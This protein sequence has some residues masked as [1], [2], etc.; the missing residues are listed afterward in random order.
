MALSKP[1]NN[2]GAS[3]NPTTN[4]GNTRNNNGNP[5]EN[6]NKEE[7]QIGLSEMIKE[8]IDKDFMNDTNN[9]QNG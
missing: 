6:K 4:G 9:K 7:P 2:K 5:Y 8:Y 3:S 1:M